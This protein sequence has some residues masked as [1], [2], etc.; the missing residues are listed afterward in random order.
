MICN[1]KVEA[2]MEHPFVRVVTLKGSGAA[3]GAVASKAGTKAG[4]IILGPATF[5]PSR[6]TAAPLVTRDKRSGELVHP[7]SDDSSMRRQRLLM[8]WR[9]KEFIEIGQILWC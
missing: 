7:S 2:A 5:L 4:A 6:K 8:V 3:G 9:R 1:E